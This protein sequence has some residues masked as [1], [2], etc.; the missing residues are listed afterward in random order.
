MKL[1]KSVEKLP[2][3]DTKAIV[4]ESKNS[5]REVISLMALCVVDHAKSSMKGPVAQNESMGVQW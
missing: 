1:N 4:L 5:R 2:A 3:L